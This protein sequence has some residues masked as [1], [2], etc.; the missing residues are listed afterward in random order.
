MANSKYREDG[1]R[2][3]DWDLQMETFLVLL[4]EPGTE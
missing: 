4:T 2:I 3:E 1:G